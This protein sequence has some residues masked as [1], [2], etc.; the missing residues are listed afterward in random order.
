MSNQF[1]A[2]WVFGDL[3]LLGRKEDDAELNARIAPH[4]KKVN[5]PGYKSLVGNK[6]AWCSLYVD[7]ALT[8]AG[9]EGTKSA[10]AYSWS[11][12]GEKCHFV[13]GAICD[14][15]HKSG[16]RHVCFFLYWIDEK[17]KIAA[18]LDGN[19]SNRLAVNETDL[20]GRG[21]TLVS[22]PRAPKGWVGMRVSKA[23]VLEA[24]PQLK[25]GSRGGSSTR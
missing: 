1:N 7:Y 4:W 23:E 10:G 8:K 18:T 15:R 25:V 17:K 13:F 2:R 14:I 12:W 9:V 11:R 20:S 3:D 19:R 24:Y 6:R 21:D 16:G 22:G 5:L